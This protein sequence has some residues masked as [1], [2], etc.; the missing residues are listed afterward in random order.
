MHETEAKRENDAN[1]LAHGEEIVNKVV[2]ILAIVIAVLFRLQQNVVAVRGRG[3][4]DDRH[5][6][7]P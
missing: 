3:F 7:G 6:R 5:E 1:N 4:C 2:V